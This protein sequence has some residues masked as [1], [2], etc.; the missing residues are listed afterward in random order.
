MSALCV[1]DVSAVVYTGVYSP[2]YAQLTSFGYPTGGINFFMSQLLVPLY[3]ANDIVLCFDSPSFR[4]K[5]HSDYKSGRTRNGAAIT[6]IESLYEYLSQ[7]GFSCYKVDGYEA[8]DIIEWVVAENWTKYD[9]II[10]VGNDMD[11]C[12]SIR[13]NVVFRSCRSDMNMIRKSSFPNA[14]KKDVYIP[15]NMVSAYKC[16]CGCPSDSVPVF[17]R[18]NGDSG[19]TLYA[20]CVSVY[21]KF[22]LVNFFDRTANPNVLRVWAEK[23]DGFSE[24]DM[25]NL[26]DRIELIFPA[27]RPDGLTFKVSS[28]FTVDFFKLSVVLTMF[29]VSDAFSSNEVKRIPLDDAQKQEMYKLANKYKSGA[30]NADR[31]LPLSGNDRIRTSPITIDA[32]E[33]DF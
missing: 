12:H 19:K 8:D 29:N 11:L 21:E 22:N 6:Q 28:R 17:R 33:K 32:F 14:L 20:R 10:I 1:I 30:F 27:K 26:D 15:Y 9:N 5:K 2:R 24:N 25:K 31:N 18:E 16:L 7:C 4:V 3:E 13:P 23:S